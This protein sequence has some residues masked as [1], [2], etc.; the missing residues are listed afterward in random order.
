MLY[1]CCLLMSLFVWYSG[2]IGWLRS[3][4]QMYVHYSY[5]TINLLAIIVLCAVLGMVH[6]M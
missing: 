4:N 1:L 6:I 2:P 3:Q 5:N